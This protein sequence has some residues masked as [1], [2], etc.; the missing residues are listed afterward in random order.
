MIVATNLSKSFGKIRAVDAI[1]LRIS[2]GR[3][4]GFLGRNGAGKTTTIRMIAGSLPP[5]TGSVAV[6][7]LDV[8]RYPRE[9]RR[10]IGYL[11]ESAPLYTEMRVVEYLRFRSRLFGVPRGKRKMAIDSAMLIGAVLTQASRVPGAML[12]P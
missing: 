10:R 6:D 1:D 7:G 3:V 11:P 12:A 2:R 8:A 4:V 9:V 5:T